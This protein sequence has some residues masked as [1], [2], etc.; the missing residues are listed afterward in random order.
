MYVHMSYSITDTV[1]FPSNTI[2]AHVFSNL[3]K[4]EGRLMKPCERIQVA[5]HM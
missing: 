1:Y 3:Q 5:T 2:A 4:N